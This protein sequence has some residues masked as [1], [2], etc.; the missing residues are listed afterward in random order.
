MVN[1]MIKTFYGTHVNRRDIFIGSHISGNRND[2]LVLL[3][4]FQ[5]KHFIIIQVVLVELKHF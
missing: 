2:M 5:E 3:K 1:T 4:R